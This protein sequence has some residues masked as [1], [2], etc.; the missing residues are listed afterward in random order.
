MAEI[1]QTNRTIRVKIVYYGPPLGGKTTNLLR[2]HAHALDTRRGE[3]ISINS[4]QDRTILF[5]LLPFTVV[6]PRGFNLRLQLLAVPGQALYSATRRA[7][8]RGADGVVFVA[9]SATDR[10]QENLTSYSEMKTHL[11]DHGIDPTAIPFA[12]QYNKRD[13]PL[14]TEVGV[15]DLGLRSSPQTAFL[16]VANKGEGVVATF[17][18]ILARTLRDL[19]RKFRVLTMEDGRTPEQFAQETVTSVFGRV[20]PAEMIAGTAGTEPRADS[21]LTIRVAVSGAAGD[22]GRGVARSPGAVAEAYAEACTELAARLATVTAERDEAQADLAD[23]RRALAIAGDL[24]R[25][26]ATMTVKR[27]LACVAESAGAAHASFAFVTADG[28]DRVVGLPGDGNLLLDSPGGRRYL[29]ALA[30][31]D[32]PCVQEAAC[33]LELFALLGEGERQLSALV[34]LP[35]RTT[36]RTVGLA[37]LYF[38]EEDP[39]PTPAALEHLELLASVFAAPLAMAARA[40]ATV[41]SEASVAVLAAAS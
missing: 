23:A 36:S 32:G 31:A 5:D 38:L 28:F 16:A 2:L 4:L 20:P 33:D 10:W 27:M 37:V 13:L 25:Q 30:Q 40:E 19:S 29:Q 8:L 7:A 24:E 17:E 3:M 11:I 18:G 15:M 12:L 21:P 14:V 41:P 35:L 22:G 26:D 34:S 9:N 6:G 1:D 39:L